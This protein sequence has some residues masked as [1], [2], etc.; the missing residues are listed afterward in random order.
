V[1]RNQYPLFSRLNGRKVIY[2]LENKSEGNHLLVVHCLSLLFFVCLLKL[3]NITDTLN[4][5]N[6]NSSNR[7]YQPEGARRF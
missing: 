2:L 3:N 1:R 5:K 4:K 7:Q 6:T